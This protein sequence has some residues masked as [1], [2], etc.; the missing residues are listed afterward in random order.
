MGL[1]PDVPG[2]SVT[3]NLGN[4]CRGRQDSMLWTLGPGPV[5]YQTHGMHRTSKP[6]DGQ[7]TD[8]QNI[9]PY[10]LDLMT[11]SRCNWTS[12]PLQQNR[13][14]TGQHTPWLGTAAV[15]GRTCTFWD[16]CLAMRH[17]PLTRQRDAY[18][19]P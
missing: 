12:L 3:K 2:M 17:L 10:L 13:G 18:L 19:M 1:K 7:Q 8:K 4:A 6:W 9:C 16:S 11:H 5:D 15:G 14:R